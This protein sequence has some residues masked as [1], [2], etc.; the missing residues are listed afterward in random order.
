MLNN[1]SVV[2]VV[3]TS[4]PDSAKRF[5]EQMLGLRLVL[6][7][8]FAIVF[9]A[10]G[11]MLRVQKV[12]DHTPPPYTVLGWDV[13]DIPASVKELAGKGVSCEGYAWLGQDESGVWSAPSGEEIDCFK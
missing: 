3:A 12:Q 2:A 7:D 5:Y 13:A 8:A 11:V 4:R 1:S 9:D 10:N 6:D